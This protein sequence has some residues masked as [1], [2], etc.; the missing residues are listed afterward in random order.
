MELTIHTQ[1]H[2]IQAV[3][4]LYSYM[5]QNFPLNYSDLFAMNMKEEE[6]VTLIPNKTVTMNRTGGAKP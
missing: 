3:L 2:I 6:M 1:T 5:R 4:D